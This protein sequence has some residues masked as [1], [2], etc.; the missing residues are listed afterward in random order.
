VSVNADR[1]EPWVVARSFQTGDEM[2]TRS[3]APDLG[4][5]EADVDAADRRLAQALT[6]EAQDALDGEWAATV[7]AR[8]LERERAL[9][10]LG[11]ARER[12]GVEAADFRL[13]DSWD[14][15]SHAERRDALALF[16][17]AIYVGRKEEG[18]PGTPLRFVARGPGAEAEVTLP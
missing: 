5:L 2:F 6:P 1:L 10:A 12:A 9:S 18:T 7:K 17:R 16:W 14:G 13:R 11:E 4:A 8:R 15:L 3:E